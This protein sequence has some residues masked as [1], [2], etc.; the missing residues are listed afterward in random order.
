MSG[1]LQAT[2]KQY[3]GYDSFRPLQREAIECVLEHRDSVI[4]LPTGGGKSLCFQLPALV[5]PGMAVV[6]SPLIALMK[7]QVD[8]LRG[9][10]VAAAAINSTLSTLE[11][12]EID[13]QIRGGRLKVLYVTPERLVSDRFIEY[14]RNN[15]LSFVAVDEA[16]CISQWGHDFRPEYR[17][18]GILREAFP[19]TGI[20]AYTATATPQ[21]RHD[22][23]AQLGL[24]DAVFHT[25]PFDRPNLYYRV[26]PRENLQSQ[27]REVLDRNVG[28]SGI[29]Y[30]IR[31]K[32][33]DEM[34]A[35]L[36]KQGHRALPYHAGMDNDS[37]RRNQESFIRGEADIIVATVAFGMGIDKPDVRFV[38][39]TGLPKSIE[40]Y[41]QESGRAG[42][43]GLNSECV[44]LFS[45]A[46]YVMWRGIAEKEG[47]DGAAMAVRK[48]GEML[49]YCTQPKCRHAALTGYFGERMRVETCVSCDV[50]TGE[51]PGLEN[52]RELTATILKAILD[53]GER[54]G[55]A[56]V[57]RLLAGESD[58]RMEGNGHTRLPQF[59]A[60]RGTR[61]RDIHDWIDQLAGQGYI[62]F[63]GE[64]RVCEL[65]ARAREHLDGRE[66]FVPLLSGG[67]PARAP[68]A[69][70]STRVTLLS[71]PQDRALFDSLRALRQ[72]LAHEEGVPPYIIFGDRT[73]VAM[74]VARPTNDAEFAQVHGVGSIKHEKYGAQF[75]AHVRAWCDSHGEASA[76]GEEATLASPRPKRV[77]R[78]EMMEQALMHFRQGADIECVA[79]ELHRA[80]STV[81]GYLV[82]AVEQGLIADVSPWVA[83][84]DLVA[85]HTLLDTR[86]PSRHSE[87]RE[88]LGEELDYNLIRLAVA[89]YEQQQRG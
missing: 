10:G 30:C 22:I 48:V 73:L 19:E 12:R 33:V 60:L 18:L 89:V 14:L 5:L 56:Y 44:L 49:D 61:S 51:V 85:I 78:N 82:D 31:R 76:P 77:A 52:A 84:A 37:R 32:D 24:R 57:A 11:R 27:V 62:K 17:G 42:R 55:G 63:A 81:M 21:V 70:R 7:D 79:E 38:L 58:E 36:S 66:T 72:E 45:K 2:L 26:L 20:H 40:H 75:I 86:G 8:A 13:E 9:M 68:K 53:T 28:E 34:C 25:G 59:G 43:D 64:Y 46:D 74:S 6:V 4:V 41:Q 16:H 39:H 71:T 15:N 23:A 50:C 80:P 29:I 83:E 65:G 69:A 54:F 88:A 47:G 1:K 87:I 3:W 35:T 67:K